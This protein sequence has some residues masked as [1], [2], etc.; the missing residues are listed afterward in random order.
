MPN[1]VLLPEAGVSCPSPTRPAPSAPVSPPPLQLGFRPHSWS[2]S[3]LSRSPLFLANLIVGLSSHVA[4]PSAALD[5]S[6]SLGPRNTFFTCLPGHCVLRFPS[7]LSGRLSPS[8]LL[9]PPLPLARALR[10]LPGP[11]PG[12][13]RRLRVITGDAVYVAEASRLPI[14]MLPRPPSAGLT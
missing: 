2:D 11:A 12:P 1:S 4:Q 8:S 6:W 14:P 13:A 10:V 5:C 3:V 7:C 9:S